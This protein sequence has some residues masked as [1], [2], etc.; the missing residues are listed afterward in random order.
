MLP[1]QTIR[2]ATDF[3]ESSGLAFQVASALAHDYNARL[4]IVHVPQPPVVIYSPAGD[5]LPPGP[6]YRLVAREQLGRLVIPANVRAE[7]R[8]ADG[9]VGAAILKL[10]REVRADLIV[11]GTHGRTGMDRWIVGSVAEEV[12]RKASCPVLTVKTPI[13]RASATAGAAASQAVTV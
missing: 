10:A 1:M 8:L 4:V 5:L 12:L 2:Y 11:L 13:A 3:S 6:D 9:E 7:Y